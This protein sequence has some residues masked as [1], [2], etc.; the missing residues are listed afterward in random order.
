MT[1]I[2]L[3]DIRDDDDA[4]VRRLHGDLT[5]AGFHIWFHSVS[6]PSRRLTVHQE[7]RDAVAVRDR[8]LQAAIPELLTC[9]LS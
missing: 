4:F 8:L 7:T 1:S 2:L 3:S 9:L 5:N 6:V